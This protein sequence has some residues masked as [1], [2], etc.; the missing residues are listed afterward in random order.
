MAG[1]EEEVELSVVDIV[2]MIHLSVVNWGGEEVARVEV[3]PSD[4]VLVGQLQIEDQIGV[5]PCKQRLVLGEEQLEETELWSVYGVLDWSSVQIT[6]INEVWWI[7]CFIFDFDIIV[8][9]LLLLLSNRES[10]VAFRKDGKLLAQ[11]IRDS[12]GERGHGRKRF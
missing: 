12:L 3:L 9:A 11:N 4:T 2:A 5:P 7:L 10:S 6:V 8:K 1:C